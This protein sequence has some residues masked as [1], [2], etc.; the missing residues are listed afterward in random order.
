MYFF[1][2]TARRRCPQHSDAAQMRWIAVLDEMRAGTKSEESCHRDVARCAIA[3]RRASCSVIAFSLRRCWR[4]PLLSLRG[5]LRIPRRAVCL[6]ARLE[7]PSASERSD[8][9]VV[10]AG[11]REWRRCGRNY[12]RCRW[13]PHCGAMRASGRALTLSRCES[14]WIDGLATACFVYRF[15][16]CRRTDDARCIFARHALRNERVD[17]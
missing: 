3:D 5:T 6:F 13:L 16:P 11:R 4:L 12:L 2:W 10:P 7:V 17:R 14:W 9:R 15:A 8:F 1:S